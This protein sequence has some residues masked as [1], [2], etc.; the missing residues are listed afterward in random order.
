MILSIIR[1]EIIFFYR[2]SAKSRNASRLHHIVTV[3]ITFAYRVS[4]LSIKT[5]GL[6]MTYLRSTFTRYI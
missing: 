6:K 3:S 1:D 2:L 4:M 5:E